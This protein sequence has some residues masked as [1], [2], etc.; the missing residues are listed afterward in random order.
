MTF[1]NITYF[2]NPASKLGRQDTTIRRSSDGAKTWSSSLLVERGKSA[3]YSCLVDG[4]LAKGAGAGL[5]GGLLYEA[6]AS[7]IKF[8]AF[9]LHF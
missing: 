7:T 3:G 5:V 1:G 8:V 6:P 9:P 2:S 4:A